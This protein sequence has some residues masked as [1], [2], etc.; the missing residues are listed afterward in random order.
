MAG[1]TG[2]RVEIVDDLPALCDECVRRQGL[3]HRH[4]RDV[5]P[6]LAQMWW[7]RLV[8]SDWNDGDKA[9][10]CVV[11]VDPDEKRRA[12]REARKRFKRSAKAAIATQRKRSVKRKRELVAAL[13]QVA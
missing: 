3:C 9:T 4:E 13:R 12:K 11:P 7:Y 1:Y 6:Q 10:D 8:G 5:L 2:P